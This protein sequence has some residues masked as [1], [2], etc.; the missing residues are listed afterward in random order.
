MTGNGRTLKKRTD[1]PPRPTWPP[2]DVVLLY[3]VLDELAYATALWDQRLDVEIVTD[4]DLT[5]LARRVHK[6]SRTYFFQEGEFD[7]T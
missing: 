7:E 1:Q 3:A 4:Q 5:N 6:S 2:E